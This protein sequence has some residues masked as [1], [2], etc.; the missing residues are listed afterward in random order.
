MKTLKKWLMILGSAPAGFFIAGACCLNGVIHAATG[1]WWALVDFATMVVWTHVA[2][3]KLKKYFVECLRL[4]H[5]HG[6]K[7]ALDLAEKT[8][9]PEDALGKD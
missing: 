1:S 2:N 9:G 6:L 4:G 8:L 5:L 3:S 7:E